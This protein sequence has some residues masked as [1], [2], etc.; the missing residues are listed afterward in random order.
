MAY[1]AAHARQYT[2]TDSYTGDEFTSEYVSRIPGIDKGRQSFWRGSQ[3][4]APSFMVEATDTGYTV[5]RVRCKKLP[6]VVIATLPLMGQALTLVDWLIRN[7]HRLLVADAGYAI[8][9]LGHILE[10]TQPCA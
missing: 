3:A 7:D 6:D 5:S 2:W 4:N 8:D 1:E 9:L 10:L